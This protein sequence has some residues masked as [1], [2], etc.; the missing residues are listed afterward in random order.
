[1]SES[2]KVKMH[3]YRGEWIRYKERFEQIQ[4]HCQIFPLIEFKEPM[5]EAM[6]RD[7][8]KKMLELTNLV[9]SEKTVPAKERKKK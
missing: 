4:Y 6:F 5:D 7:W 9:S 2:Y 1:M 3:L 8:W